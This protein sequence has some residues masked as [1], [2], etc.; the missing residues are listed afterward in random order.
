MSVPSK[1]PL[2]REGRWKRVGV[3]LK[4]ALGSVARKLKKLVT[5]LSEI[6][7]E[8]AQLS[9]VHVL[10]MEA[11]TALRHEAIRRVIPHFNAF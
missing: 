4:T 2:P 9:T 3:R 7:L 1:A 10:R 11:I 5:I 8:E 6:E